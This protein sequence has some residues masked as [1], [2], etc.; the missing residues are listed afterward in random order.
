MRQ[1]GVKAPTAG[2][3]SGLYA[4]GVNTTSPSYKAAFAKCRSKLQ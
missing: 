2:S 3:L 4:S 1:N